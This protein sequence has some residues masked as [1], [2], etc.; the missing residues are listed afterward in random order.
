MNASSRALW[1]STVL[2]L[3]LVGCST[4]PSYDEQTRER[5]VKIHTE[6]GA[7]YMQRNQLKVAQHE[8]E[9]ALALDSS[10]SDANNIMGLLQARL[11]HYD[12]ADRAFRKSIE[13]R[14][15]NGDAQNNYGVFLCERNRVDDAVRHFEL[16]IKNPFYHTPAFADVNAGICMLKK[17]ATRRAGNY[18]REALGINPKL[19]EALFQMAKLDLQVNDPVAARGYIQRFFQA[20][21][22]T[23]D[24]L[25]LAVRIELALHNR[26]QAEN[27]ALRLRGKFPD[28]L[29]AQQLR[30]LGSL[31]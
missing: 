5:L 29:Q 16:A 1:A 4:T 2:A 18:F 11:G 22:E 15:D 8:L 20:A 7:G 25:L 27:Y 31:N 9:Q 13:S 12:K 30:T 3:L 28:S 10:D 21:P 26:E 17:G 6:L 24:A 14:P 19:P 23:P